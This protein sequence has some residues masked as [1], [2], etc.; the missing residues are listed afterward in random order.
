MF[1]FFNLFNI[2]GKSLIK[3]PLSCIFCLVVI[4]QLPFSPYLATI[5]AI[6]FNCSELII[7]L[8]ILSLNINFPGVF[9]LQNIPYHFNLNSKSV[10]SICSHPISANLSISFPISSPSLAALFFSTLFSFLPSR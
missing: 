8:G 5:D 9:G 7:P 2:S 10:L 4:S 3:T 1:T 6:T